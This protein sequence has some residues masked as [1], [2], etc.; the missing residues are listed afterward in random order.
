MA[1]LKN[2]LDSNTHENNGSPELSPN[3]TIQKPVLIKTGDFDFSCFPCTE[4]LDFFMFSHCTADFNFFMFSLL[5]VLGTLLF[6]V[7]FLY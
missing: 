4:D 7:F 2:K 3:D 5:P 1:N 6:H